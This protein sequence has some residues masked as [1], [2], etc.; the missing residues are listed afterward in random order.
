MTEHIKSNRISRWIRA[1]FILALAIM[2][3][4]AIRIQSQRRAVDA[5]PIIWAEYH[6]TGAIGWAWN[7]CGF[8]AKT[9]PWRPA[10][11]SLL[12][13]SKKGLSDE[14]ARIIANQHTLEILGFSDGC[15]M[16]EAAWEKL[17]SLSSLRGFACSH[18]PIPGS[19]DI[20]PQHLSILEFE[21]CGLTDANFKRHTPFKGSTVW[22]RH[23]SL[24]AAA[25]QILDADSLQSINIQSNPVSNDIFDALRR[26]KNLRVV[27]LDDT[28]IEDCNL[29]DLSWVQQLDYLRVSNTQVGDRFAALIAQ[30]PPTS[31]YIEK[32]AISPFGVS[33]LLA[34]D[35]L[36]CLY[37][38]DNQLP[39]DEA[40]WKACQVS[41]IRVRRHLLNEDRVRYHYSGDRNLLVKELMEAGDVSLRELG[42][43]IRMSAPVTTKIEVR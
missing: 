42:A 36:Q 41:F 12:V 5:L 35:S 2:P 21:G 19:L 20:L 17:G 24:S 43:T 8:D 30:Q 31:L 22:L 1:G 40:S 23:N 14:Q 3:V 16:S 29:P 37:V 15:H 27:E 11:K 4:V 33:K 9:L 18:Q 7:A 25:L 6:D 10:V 13:S 39:V 26:F 34:A 32:T 28:L 38:D